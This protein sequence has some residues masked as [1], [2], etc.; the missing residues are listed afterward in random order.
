MRPRLLLLDVDFTILYP[1]RVFSGPGYAE[2][3]RRHGLELDPERYEPARQQASAALWGEQ[4]SLDHDG[5]EHAT[6]TRLIVEGMGGAGEVVERVAS[7]AA[8]AWND[9]SNFALYD[10]VRPALTRL[11]RAGIPVGLVSNTH[12]ELGDFI[13]AFGLEVSFALS[14]RVHGRVKPCPTIFA[15]ALALAGVEAAA[16]V[17]VG[18]TPAADVEGARAAGLRGILLDR[19]ERY[20]EAGPDRIGSLDELSLLLDLS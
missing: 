9:P 1:S 14:S 17:M 7:A 12:R 5:A 16:A 11:E 20:P 3:A 2:L 18:D 19:E 15:A 6:F 8:D 10:D 4:R 13:A